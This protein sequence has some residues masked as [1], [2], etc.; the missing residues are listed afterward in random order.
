MLVGLFCLVF[1]CWFV[2]YAVVGCGFVK[3]VMVLALFFFGID[4]FQL[5]VVHEGKL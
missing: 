3:H 5:N 1:G 4:G 2:D